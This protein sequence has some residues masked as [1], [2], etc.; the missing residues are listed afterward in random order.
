[1]LPSESVRTRTGEL[2]LFSVVGVFFVLFVFVEE[3][4]LN[5]VFGVWTVLSKLNSEIIN[6]FASLV[7]FVLSKVQTPIKC[8]P[9]FTFERLWMKGTNWIHS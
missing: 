9:T 8:F 1:M 4:F 5:A 6:L 7:E 3:L 2:K